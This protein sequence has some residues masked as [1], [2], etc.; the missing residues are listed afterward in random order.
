[1]REGRESGRLQLGKDRQS[2]L[3]YP[4]IFPSLPFPLQ[5]CIGGTSLIV[6]T[7]RID[8]LF[9]YLFVDIY[10]SFYLY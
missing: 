3:V 6:K 5:M 1:M 8:V 2:F 4:D 9:R 7:F 10:L